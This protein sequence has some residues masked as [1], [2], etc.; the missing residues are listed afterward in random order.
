M[1]KVDKLQDLLDPCLKKKIG[2]IACI[3]A[4]TLVVKKYC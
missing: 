1:F 2:M 4:V 3:K